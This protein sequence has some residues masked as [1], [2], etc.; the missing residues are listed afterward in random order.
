MRVSV[1][2]CSKLNKM[3]LTCLR[4]GYS[5]IEIWVGFSFFLRGPF[6][7]KCF[8]SNLMKF[9]SSLRITRGRRYVENNFVRPSVHP[10]VS[11][12]VCDLVS[13]TKTFVGF[14]WSSI[15]QLVTKSRWASTSFMKISRMTVILRS[16]N[17]CFYPYF[18][19]VLR[20]GWHFAWDVST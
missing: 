8:F 9:R 15:W 14:L 13:E 11:P 10:P 16:V 18:S 20:Y 12:R 3:Y 19:Y 6:S 2:Y 1:S 17:M 4:L 7:R 5:L